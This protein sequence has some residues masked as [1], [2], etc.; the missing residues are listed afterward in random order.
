MPFMLLTTV[1]NS[2]YWEISRQQLHSKVAASKQAW[3]ESRYQQI[4]VK[5]T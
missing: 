2:E 3:C 5:K 1:I 4:N